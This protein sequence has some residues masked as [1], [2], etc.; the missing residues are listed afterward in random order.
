MRKTW[1]TGPNTGLW[2]SFGPILPLVVAFAIHLL[3]VGH[4]EPGGG[5]IAG[6]LIAGAIALLA[7]AD[8]EYQ[9]RMTKPEALI[10]GGLLLAAVMGIAPL[11]V[12]KALLEALKHT[13]DLGPIGSFK[14]S[15]I[16][17]FDIGVAMVVVGLADAVM[18][19]IRA[20]LR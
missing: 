19:R 8:P 15:S 14:L 13:F 3:M 16:L 2:I 20:A 11:V 17:L 7:V 6:L 10:G 4:D 5:F 1:Q 12:G 18:D 9:T